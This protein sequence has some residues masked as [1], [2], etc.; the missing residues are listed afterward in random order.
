[1]LSPPFGDVADRLIRFGIALFLPLRGFYFIIEYTPLSNKIELSVQHYYV[2]TTRI[3][4]GLH[5]PYKG[6]GLA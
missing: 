3:A 4:G 6:L 2:K 1:M 5:W